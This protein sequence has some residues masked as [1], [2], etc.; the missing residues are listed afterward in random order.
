M[1]F[2]NGE[3]WDIRLVP[4]SHPGLTTPE[5]TQALGCCDD[6]RKTIYIDETLHPSRMRKILCHEITHAAMYSYNIEI[7]DPE[8]EMLAELVS[9][10]GHEIVSLTNKISNKLKL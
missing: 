3:G 9:S 10:Y 6:I 5:G 8:E 4:S 2:V 1:I 7:P